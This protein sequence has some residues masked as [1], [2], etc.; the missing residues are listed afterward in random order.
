MILM[1]HG[2][3]LYFLAGL[4]AFLIA[5]ILYA[6]AFNM[7]RDAAA[8]SVLRHRP[9][10]LLPLVLYLAA[11]VS[12]LYPALAVDFRLPVLAYALIIGTMVTFALNRYRRVSDSSFALVFGGAL[13]FMV[14]DSLLAVNMFLCHGKL[15]MAGLGI[16]ATY[17]AAQYLIAKGMA[18]NESID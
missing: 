8:T 4:S 6:I 13:L 15:F 17:M 2:N 18:R 16:M 9:W 11:F 12:V 5:H 7:V 1:Q 3:A 14:S 10:L